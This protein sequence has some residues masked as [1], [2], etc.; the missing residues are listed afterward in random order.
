MKFT[1]NTNHSTFELKGNVI[2]VAQW[3]FRWP[4]NTIVPCS[5]HTA[6]RGNSER[7]IACISE[8]RAFWKLNQF[9]KRVIFDTK[10]T[11]NICGITARFG[12]GTLHSLDSVTTIWAIDVQYSRIE[13]WP[14]RVYIYNLFSILDL[15]PNRTSDTCKIQSLRLD[16]ILWSHRWWKVV[17][18]EKLINIIIRNWS[19][20]GFAL[21]LASSSGL[22]GVSCSQAPLFE[23]CLCH[24]VR[25]HV[26]KFYLDFVKNSENLK[27]S[28]NGEVLRIFGKSNRK[29]NRVELYELPSPP[30]QVWSTEVLFQNFQI[31]HDDCPK[32]GKFLVGATFE[33]LQI[34]KKRIATVGNHVQAVGTC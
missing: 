32:L 12:P 2:L 17:L 16:R 8:S 5:H 3:V 27:T 9:S 30:H 31:F 23:T 15:F 29:F 14:V 1:I 22:T 20:S 13:D 26:Y 18:S 34:S 33:K 24:Y 7:I 19:V 25:I 28:K 10:C 21:L 11:C 6:A 4:W